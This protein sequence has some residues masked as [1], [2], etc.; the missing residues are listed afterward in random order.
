MKF[1]KL[2]DKYQTVFIKS[3]FTLVNTRCILDI[4]FWRISKLSIKIYKAYKYSQHQ[5]YKNC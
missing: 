4:D 1:E 3:I 5:Q 2:I